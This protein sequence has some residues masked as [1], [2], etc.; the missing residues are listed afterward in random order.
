MS[1]PW[2]EQGLGPKRACGY[3]AIHE[4]QLGAKILPKRSPKSTPFSL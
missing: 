2:I 4:V 3:T 1:R